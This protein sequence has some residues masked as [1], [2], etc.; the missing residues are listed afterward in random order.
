MHSAVHSSIPVHCKAG[1]VHLYPGTPENTH[2]HSCAHMRALALVC[3]HRAVHTGTH[4]MCRYTPWHTHAQT[5]TH[6][7]HSPAPFWKESS[8]KS[9]ACYHPLSKQY[10]TLCAF[11]V[12]ID[13]AVLKE[14]LK[15][16]RAGFLPLAPY[17]TRAGGHKTYHF[18]LSCLSQEL[19]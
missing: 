3:V 6:A 14:R 17:R 1:Y 9:T 11:G 12:G 4:N 13:N 10:F 16:D 5:H 7:Q 18:L 2:A 15:R 19:D 8:R